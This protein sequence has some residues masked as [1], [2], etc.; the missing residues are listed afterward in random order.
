MNAIATV[1]TEQ[2][3][4][5]ATNE[6]G[7]QA[8]TAAKAFLQ[9]HGDRDACGFAW[10]LHDTYCMHVAGSSVGERGTSPRS[11]SRTSMGTARSAP[12]RTSPGPH[13]IGSCV[14]WLVW[15]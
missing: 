8:R 3:V 6:A 5:D 12:R 2:A 14:L 7:M 11:A 15:A 9:K 4:Q 10:V 1:I 13:T